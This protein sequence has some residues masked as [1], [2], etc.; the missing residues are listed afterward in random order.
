MRNASFFYE[1]RT[2]TF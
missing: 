2:S 1:V